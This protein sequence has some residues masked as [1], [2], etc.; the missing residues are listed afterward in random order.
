MAPTLEAVSF[1]V[2]VL[3]ERFHGLYVSTVIL[4]DRLPIQSS[5][6][7]NRWGQDT[8]FFFESQWSPG[9]FLQKIR[10]LE[11]EFRAVPADF[12][13][14]DVLIAAG[15]GVEKCC[16]LNH[17]LRCSESLSPSP[18]SNVFRL[19]RNLT[20]TLA[21]HVPSGLHA[22]VTVEQLFKTSAGHFEHLG[23]LIRGCML[24][25]PRII[26]VNVKEA[27]FIHTAGLLLYILPTFRPAWGILDEF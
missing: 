10:C 12:H 5:R 9:L 25:Q 4:Q 2:L 21:L 26:R 20:S 14:R 13:G 1:F 18:L 7:P 16:W 27:H 15:A 3:P 17:W 23:I 22:I 24:F 19:H 11:K 6:R 8:F